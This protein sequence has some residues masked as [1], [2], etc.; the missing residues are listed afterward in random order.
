VV[1]LTLVDLRRR[2]LGGELPLAG[3]SGTKMP[4]I[5]AH[6]ARALAEASPASAFDLTMATYPAD[7]VVDAAAYA[8]ALAA[9]PPGSAATIFTPV[10]APSPRI[11]IASPRS[12]H[13]RRTTAFTHKPP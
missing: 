12:V 1:A 10:R 6:M 3:G 5:R 13:T 7:G 11:M 2:G 4:A 9:L 8:T